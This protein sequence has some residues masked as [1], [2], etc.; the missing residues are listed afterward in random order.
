MTSIKTGMRRKGMV[1]VV[2]GLTEGESIIV[3]GQM[4]VQPD[5][6]VNAIAPAAP[7]LPTEV[8]PLDITAPAAGDAQ[9]SGAAEASQ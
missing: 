8:E 1:E 2:E 9:K 4:K 7:P 5:T 6:P 3:A